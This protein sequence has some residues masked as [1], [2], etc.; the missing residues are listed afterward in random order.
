MGSPDLRRRT[1][2]AGRRSELESGPVWLAHSLSLPGSVLDGAPSTA[3]AELGPVLRLRM[4][5]GRV[6]RK[7][8]LGE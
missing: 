1:Y 3:A 2:E 8:A 4:S 7:S 5:D 6:E